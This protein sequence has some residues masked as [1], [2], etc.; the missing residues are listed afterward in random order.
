MKTELCA[1]YPTHQLAVSRCSQGS[2]AGHE[3]SN[4]QLHVP[5][6]PGGLV[7]CNGPHDSSGRRFS[8][9]LLWPDCVRKLPGGERSSALS[10]PSASVWVSRV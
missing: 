5:E 1:M 3:T 6:Y 8:T 7:V 9:A 4:G 2:V 10:H